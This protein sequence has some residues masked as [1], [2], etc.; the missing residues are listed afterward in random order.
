[1]NDNQEET[2]N[3]LYIPANIKRRYEFF[4]GIGFGEVLVMAVTTGLSIPVAM[5][6]NALT[7]D[8][9]RGVLVVC[10]TAAAAF[11]AVKK[12]EVNRSG[13]D[14]VRLFVRFANT[15]KQYK[16]EYKPKYMKGGA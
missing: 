5:L 14:M 6:I 7:A 15:H 9:Y 13:V 3:S 1:M 2:R 11:F 8:F 12:D 4:P 16:Y 10:V